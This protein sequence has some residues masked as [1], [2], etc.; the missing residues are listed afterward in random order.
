VTCKC[1]GVVGCDAVAMGRWIMTFCKYV[2]ASSSLSN[3]SNRLLK[4]K[5]VFFFDTRTADPV[6]SDET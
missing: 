5:A 6:T 3:S 2:L 1:S 4:M